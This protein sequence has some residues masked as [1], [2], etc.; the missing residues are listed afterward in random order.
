[1][2]GKTSA[3]FTGRSEEIR[4]HYT[5]QLQGS[6]PEP[7]AQ[8][9]SDDSVDD[10]EMFW[11]PG[12]NDALQDWRWCADQP[13]DPQEGCSGKFQKWFSWYDFSVTT[14]Y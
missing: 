1:M 7:D 10:R 4:R 14:L 9:G 6:L 8:D 3:N 2:E 12:R 13:V 5:I 11:S